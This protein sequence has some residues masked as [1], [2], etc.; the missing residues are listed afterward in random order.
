MAQFRPKRLA[1]LEPKWVAQL[2]PFYLINLKINDILK[3]NALVHTALLDA[4]LEELSEIS[5]TYL[6]E[7]SKKYI[8][9]IQGLSNAENS[10][11]DF[12]GVKGRHFAEKVSGRFL[13]IYK[14]F[15]VDNN[16]EGKLRVLKDRLW[17]DRHMYILSY[18]RLLQSYGNQVS[19]PDNPALNHQDCAAIIIAFV[20]IIDFYE[21][22]ITVNKNLP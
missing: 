7:F 10:S 12:L 18:L 20:R 13:H 4:A 21:S 14:L 1:Q 15:P 22:K 16:L 17:F 9:I 19:H 3:R 8:G 11:F 2:R 5:G 6:S